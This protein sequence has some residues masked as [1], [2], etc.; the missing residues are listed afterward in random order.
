MAESVLLSDMGRE[1]S[2]DE[3]ISMIKE[4]QEE[5]LVLQPSNT[6]TAEFICSCCGCCCGMLRVQKMLPKP[7]DFWA[8]NFHVR[9]DT[10]LCEGCGVCAKRCQVGAVG[11]P[12]KKQPAVVDLNLCIGCGVCVPTCPKEAVH[13]V[14][15]PV[16][17]KP[18]ESLEDLY[19]IIM[20]NKKGWLGK[21]RLAGKLFVDAIRTGRT[22]LM[23]N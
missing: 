7:L 10:N 6:E 1:I 5:G 20:A 3:A 8:T 9:V 4:N 11:V 14:K 12:E 2:R 18:P 22:D 15:R 17:V 16:E 23:N 13:L 21:V 19:E